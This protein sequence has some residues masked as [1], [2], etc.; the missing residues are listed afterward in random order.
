MNASDETI[1][2]EGLLQRVGARDRKAFASLYE[3]TSSR[4]YGVLMRILSDE[5]DA[6]DVLQEVYVSIWNRAGQ[7]DPAK[8]KPLAWMGVITR[9]AAIDAIRRRRPGH[10]SDENCHELEDGGRSPLEQLQQTMLRR[11][12]QRDLETL[13]AK[14]RDALRM[15]YLEERSLNEVAEIMNAPVNTAKS[16]VRRGIANLQGKNKDRSISDYL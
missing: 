3:Q 2:L 9:N 15:Y 11:A 6:S 1:I 5:R 8:G 7:F 13:P 4:L 14:Q 12:V 10:V 16:W